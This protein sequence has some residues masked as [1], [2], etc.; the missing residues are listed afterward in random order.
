M[1]ACIF[2]QHMNLPDGKL[3][4]V[5]RYSKFGSISPKSYIV[6]IYSHY[7]WKTTMLYLLLKQKQ[8]IARQ[9][10]DITIIIIAQR[11]RVNSKFIL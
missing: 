7:I 4:F 11:H 3:T 6:A 5:N 9:E 1:P 2:Q 10:D 8:N